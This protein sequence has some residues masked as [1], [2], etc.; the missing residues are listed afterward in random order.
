MSTIK[1]IAKMAGV[2]LSTASR[3]LRGQG[4]VSEENLEKVKQAAKELNYFPN[5][6]A[7]SLRYS[8]SSTVGIMFMNGN[9]VLGEIQTE[10]ER[11]LR[12]TGYRT[13]ITYCGESIEWERQC[14]ESLIS[15]QVDGVILFPISKGCQELID[16]FVQNG[17]AVLQ[18]F[19]RQYRG[20]DSIIIDDE[21]A[22]YDAVNL[23]LKKGHR[24]ISFPELEMNIQQG[25][26]MIN[27]C[28][29]GYEHALQEYGLS[30]RLEDVY[31]M[32]GNI[33]GK[34]YKQALKQHL[35]TF[36]PSAILAKA[37][38]IVLQ[39]LKELN[40]RVPEDV[41]V[42]AYEDS[43]WCEYQEL[44]ALSH[45]VSHIGQEMARQILENLESVHQA[46]KA[47]VMKKFRPQLIERNS[48]AF[49]ETR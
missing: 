49:L 43:E 33:S 19:S 5:A 3:A 27:E 20:I 32:P 21:Q 36:H 18:V 28:Y 25:H 1:E 40:L 7:V 46:G 44:T 39:C 11:A 30:S 2:S 23:L 10:I 14:L 48:T 47:E 6:T 24:R 8:K 37:P 31:F 15:S 29:L 12:G 13:L 22:T 26:C 4:Y 16:N 38:A 35:L 45:P 41:S 34:S 17:K 9:G 42:I